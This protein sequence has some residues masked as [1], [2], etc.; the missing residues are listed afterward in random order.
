MKKLLRI[1]YSLLVLMLTGLSITSCSDV[2]EAHYGLDNTGKIDSSIFEYIQTRDDLSIFE[3]MIRQTRY[4][5]VLNKSNAYTVW[6]PNN[7]SLE[8]NPILLDT[9][10]WMNF[11][12]N[13]IASYAHP[14]S[15]ADSMTITMLNGKRL[16][17]NANELS[18][19]MDNV[20]LV[21]KDIATKNGLLQI[22]NDVLPYRNNVW[23]NM[24][25]YP[26]LD[27]L[28]AYLRSMEI[29]TFDE[30]R[31]FDNSV[32]IDSFFIYTNRV[33]NLLGYFNVE[34]SIYTSILPDNQAW[35]EAYNRILPYFKTKAADGGEAVQR[36]NT[37]WTM[38]QDL[39]FWDR[40][41]L[42]ITDSIITSTSWNKLTN[43]DSLFMNAEKITLS[44]GFAYKTSK[45]N[46]KPK[47]SWC[48]EIRVEAENAL[49]GRASLNYD[50]TSFS[51][52]GTK[53]NLSRNS[54]IYCR[55]TSTS[56]LSQLTMTFPIPNTLS[57]KYNIY[58]VFVPTV[59]T[60][61]T[62]K[63]PYKVECSLSYNVNAAV[64]QQLFT[65]FVLPTNVT[66]SVKVTKLLIAKDFEFATTNISGIRGLAGTI[67]PK[68]SGLTSPTNIGLKIRNIVGTSAADKKNFNRDMRIDCIL[69]EPV[70]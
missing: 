58:A 13:H 10:S 56:A 62:D 40:I 57:T 30:D 2:W 53:F 11:V 60:D 17:F 18:A 67:V 24:L 51:S 21:E 59:V 16:V 61:S 32:F 46:H 42:P 4:D 69:L 7:A 23:E 8:G 33:R 41:N 44:N 25:L 6:A 22:I 47:D 20:S 64:N 39:F 15:Q 26:G 43:P 36:Y 45:L 48:K 38:V 5:S 68:N 54:Y 70:Q 50:V 3:G 63:R 29:R 37:Q 12:S 65:K 55:A 34:D 19:T 14:V 1:R 9:A 27:S 31:S 66:D 35:I 28:K 49:S 52:L